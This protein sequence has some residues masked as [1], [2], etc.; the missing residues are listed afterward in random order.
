L[1]ANS[2]A[3]YYVHP[4]ILY[5]L[6]YMFVPITLPLFIKAPLVILLGIFLSWVVSAFIL[7][8]APVVRRAFA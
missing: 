5:P 3:I 6:A 4:L 2:Y 8:K 1:T 7:T